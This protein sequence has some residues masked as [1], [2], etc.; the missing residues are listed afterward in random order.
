MKFALGTFAAFILSFFAVAVAVYE[1]PL[2]TE[3]TSQ[4]QAALM[5]P[6]AASTKPYTPSLQVH[7]A[8][9]DLAE[10]LRKRQKQLERRMSDI[11][12][13]YQMRKHEIDRKHEQRMNDLQLKEMLRKSNARQ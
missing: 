12:A 11:D 13:D 5:K 10:D 8:E 6:S 1:P 4:S 9:R 7:R 2:K 3:D